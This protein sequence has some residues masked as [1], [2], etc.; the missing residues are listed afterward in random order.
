MGTPLV[1]DLITLLSVTHKC[2]M[3]KRGGWCC[4]GWATFIGFHACDTHQLPSVSVLYSPETWGRPMDGG[5]VVPTQA[6]GG[7]VVGSTVE[8]TIGAEAP[9]S[10]RRPEINSQYP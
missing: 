10:I 5:M 6:N 9:G 4:G 3:R 8:I 1:E 2:V 7:V